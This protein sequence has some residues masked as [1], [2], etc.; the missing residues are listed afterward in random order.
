MEFIRWGSLAPQKCKHHWGNGLKLNY[1]KDD[2]EDFYR[3]FY[4]APVGKGI[5]A[6]PLG[7]HN[8]DLL[9]G[10]GSVATGRYNYLKDADGHKIMVRPID[11]FD[12]HLNVYHME[13]SGHGDYLHIK[14]YYL[15]LLSKMGIK[16][17][18]VVIY[19]EKNGCYNPMAW[20]YRAYWGTDH[21]PMRDGDTGEIMDEVNVDTEVIYPLAIENKPKRFNYDGRI[22]HHFEKTYP[23]R[24]FCEKVWEEW[25]NQLSPLE[26]EENFCP[27][28]ITECAT[29]T[30]LVRNKDILDRSGTWILTD[31][32]VCHQA[33]RRAV[34][35]Y[36][37][38]AMRFEADEE[39]KGIYSGLPRN[40]F[41]TG[42]FEV[43][44]EKVQ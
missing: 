8:W 2:L 14:P 41:I 24:E 30:T 13:W 1:R 26:R 37:Q 38:D 4:L 12:D 32:D 17:Q 15:N 9:H 20:V 5:Y 10:A 28:I 33:L 43:F 23:Q 34:E 35:I 18:N 42:D 40:S 25:W 21:E 44:I 27:E 3:Q 29:R 39:F 7:L 19:S 11:F 22:W 36:K 31:M 6:F 16:P